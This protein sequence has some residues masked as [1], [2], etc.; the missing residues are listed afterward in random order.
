M[1]LNRCDHMKRNF[2]SKLHSYYLCIILILKKYIYKITYMFVH[3]LPICAFQNNQVCL[4]EDC[5]CIY[6]HPSLRTILTQPVHTL[7]RL[8][9]LHFA[10]S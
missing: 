8:D 9:R 3:I 1:A 2:I 4:V 7:Y 6:F 10:H 5:D